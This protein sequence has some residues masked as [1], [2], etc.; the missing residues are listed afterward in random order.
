MNF[1]TDSRIE[2]CL[3]EN[4]QR[5]VVLQQTSSVSYA[6]CVFRNNLACGIESYVTDFVVTGCEFDSNF[7]GGMGGAIDHTDGAAYITDSVFTNNESSG[8]YGGALYVVG[9]GYVEIHNCTF[10]DNVNHTSDGG[11]VIGADAI[12]NCRFERNRAVYGDGG[13]VWGPTNIT[14]CE[15]IDNY[16]AG[17][18]GGGGAVY[19]CCTAT[20]RKCTFINNSTLEW[21]GAI[22]SV[23]GEPEII[24]CVFSG[25]SSKKGGAISKLFDGMMKIYNCVLIDNEA[26]TMGGGVYFSDGESGGG[27]EIYNSSFSGNDAPQGG[28]IGTPGWGGVC[29]LVMANSILWGNTA[30]ADPQLAI[31]SPA[32]ADVSYSCVEGGYTGTNNISTDPQFADADLRLSETSPCIEAGNND[33]VPVTLITDLDENPRIAGCFVDMGAYEFPGGQPLMGDIDGDCD[34]DLVDYEYFD[35]CL[36]LSGPGAGSIFQ[37]CIDTFDFDSDGDIDLADFAAYQQ[38]AG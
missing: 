11:A 5:R 10:T 21:G 3:F 30:T 28:A 32:T 24:D 33:A 17:S 13:A 16:A 27:V 23:N 12:S 38:L 25:N 9:D 2:Q 20:L 19:T 22:G 8:G 37:E 6:D 1:E 7:N 4:N 34:L 29:Q 26:D 35:I 36:S 15:F 18:M 14:N 31:V